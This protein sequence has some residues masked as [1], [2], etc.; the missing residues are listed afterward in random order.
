MLFEQ[1]W[2]GAV[3]YSDY[4]I[5]L[6]AVSTG[7]LEWAKRALPHEVTHLIVKEAIFG[8]FWR[9]TALVE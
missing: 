7:N 8:P 4:N 3:A 6:T 2:T 5:I 1:E 9:H